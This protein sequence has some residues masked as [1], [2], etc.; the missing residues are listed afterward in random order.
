MSNQI[1]DITGVKH[2]FD[3]NKKIYYACLYP[4]FEWFDKEFSITK[5]ISPQQ[6][7][8]L[9]Q[10]IFTDTIEK[11]DRF[12]LSRIG[13][14]GVVR[15]Y[16]LH[17]HLDN[18][19]KF[20]ADIFENKDKKAIVVYENYVTVGDTLDIVKHDFYKMVIQTKSDLGFDEE[21][22]VIDD[23]NFKMFR[24]LYKDAL[25]LYPEEVIK[26]HDKLKKNV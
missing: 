17:I 26:T 7:T 22:V 4:K 1:L 23:E 10:T 2:M 8:I 18:D 24:L 6:T 11:D 25:E 3:T 5:L 13:F 19:E 12:L 9:K 21:T 14:N 16:K 15:K 20:T